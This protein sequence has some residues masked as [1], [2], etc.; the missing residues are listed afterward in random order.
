MVDRFRYFL[1]FLKK[2]VPLNSNGYLVLQNNVN[3]CG[4]EHEATIRP[5]II[6]FLV[7]AVA[8]SMAR[9]HSDFGTMDPSKFRV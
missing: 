5:L 7:S 2:T 4:V 3:M 8:D 1:G 6:N 9:I